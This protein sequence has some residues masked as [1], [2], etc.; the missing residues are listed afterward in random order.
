MVFLDVLDQLAP[1]FGGRGLVKKL[2]KNFRFLIFRGWSGGTTVT[3]VG[4]DVFFSPSTEPPLGV[5]VKKP[6]KPFKT[7]LEPLLTCYLLGR[8]H[9][10]RSEIVWDNLK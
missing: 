8:P 1:H 9:F 3:E 10:E 6:L 5:G 4:V 2:E 7:G